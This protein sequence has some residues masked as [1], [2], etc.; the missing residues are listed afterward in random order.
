VAI[1]GSKC[2]A[3]SPHRREQAG[4]LRAVSPLL[5]DGCDVLRFC[6]GAVDEAQYLAVEFLRGP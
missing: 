6:F 1:S 3:R 4:P 5:A 2:L